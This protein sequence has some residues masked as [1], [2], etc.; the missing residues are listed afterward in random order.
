MSTNSATLPSESQ[1]K[2]RRRRFLKVTGI[3]VLLLAIWTGIDLFVP[4]TSHLK[5][6]DPDEVAR[7][8]T[9]MWRSYYDKQ[10]VKLF[11]ELAELLRKQY[12]MPFI[13]SNVV[14]FRAAKAAFVFK[15]GKQRS[16]YEQALPD[17]IKFY[18]SIRKVSDIPFDVDRVARAELEWWIIHRQ[19]AQ[20]AEGD[21][22]RSLAELQAE[23][24]HLPV[25]KFME[26]GKLRADAMTIR[27]TKEEA[28]GVSEEDWARI[29]ELLKGSWR[30]LHEAVK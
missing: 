6:F 17:L 30:S 20:H 2:P 4:R 25:E 15:R 29:N 12:K 10:R 1:R 27:D 23:I 24:Y 14:A 8:E 11:F 3:I 21:L 18:Q 26:H 16:D 13:R 19:R 5:E 7:L 9:D 28:G 22:A